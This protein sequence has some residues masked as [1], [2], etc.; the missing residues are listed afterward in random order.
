L[1]VS[2]EPISPLIYVH[3]SES[4]GQTGVDQAILNRIV[5]EVDGQQHSFSFLETQLRCLFQCE[6]QGVA[7]TCPSYLEA[8]ELYVP[9]PRY[10][11]L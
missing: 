4:S 8:D 10:F 1:K 7:L 6:I 3:L 9:T 2:G 11:F 5:S